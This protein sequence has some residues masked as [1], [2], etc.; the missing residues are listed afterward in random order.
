MVTYAGDL[1]LLRYPHRIRPIVEVWS[2]SNSPVVLP[3]KGCVVTKDAGTYPRVKAAIT[4]ADMDYLPDRLDSLLLPW[5]TQVRIRAEVTDG[6]TTAVI[7]IA[8]TWL[9]QTDVNRPASE[10][11][12]SCADV[13]SRIASHWLEKA[14]TPAKGNHVTSAI[15][16][17]V[18]RSSQ[19]HGNA[20]LFDPGV[21]GDL[22]SDGMTFTGNPW[23]AIEDLADTIGCEVFVRYDDVIVCRPVPALGTA[24]AVIDA[25]PGGVMTASATSVTRSVNRVVI[26][27]TGQRTNAGKPAADVY[28]TWQATTAP[29]SPASGYGY[30]TQVESR[31]VGNITQRQA[32]TAALHLARSLAGLTRTSQITTVAHPHLEPGDTINVRF[33]S[34]LGERAI[35]QSHV[36]DLSPA[37]ESQIGTRTTDWLAT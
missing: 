20:M 29:T 23:Q 24:R 19:S 14:Y 9:Y 3:V 5:K 7:P 11:S 10:F 6:K 33:A 15:K 22:V 27:F 12:L 18:L 31:S 30:V 4:V 25:G 1:T 36:I 2:D 37:G 17:L 34:G 13:S 26:R 35:V 28:G 8:H 32:D 16:Q 21:P